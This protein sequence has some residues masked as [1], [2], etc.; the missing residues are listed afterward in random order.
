MYDAGVMKYIYLFMQP[1]YSSRD[2]RITFDAL[3][4]LSNLLCHRC[5]HLE[6][7]ESEG[8]ELLMEVPR[9]SVASSV[10]SLVLYYAAYI[11][12]AV[13]RVSHAQ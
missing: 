11:E 13:E 10:V 8:L 4:L 3:R 2:I 7:V 12:D 9:P 6:F 1:K 5:I